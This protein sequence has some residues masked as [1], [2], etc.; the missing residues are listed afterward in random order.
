MSSI[1]GTESGLGQLLKQ[2]LTPDS[3]TTTFP[4]DFKVASPESLLV[5]LG[6]VIQEPNEDY[7][8]E[9]SGSQI[10]FSTAPTT[11]FSL[12]LLYFGREVTIPRVAGQELIR[13]RFSGDGVTTNFPLSVSYPLFEEGVIVFVDGVQQEYSNDWTL[14]N[15]T[16]E[17]VF[18]LAPTGGQTIDV[19]IHGVQRNDIFVVDDNSITRHKLALDW[20]QN[21]NGDW[22]PKI[23]N[24]KDLGTALLRPRTAYIID[25]DFSGDVT[26]QGNLEVLGTQTIFNTTV[27]D[28]EDN[29]ITINSNFTSGTPTIDGG[30]RFLRGD[31]DDALIQWDESADQWLIGTEGNL[32]P[33]ATDSNLLAHTSDTG[34]PH[35][36]T[37]AQVGLGSVTNDAQ[38]K[39]AANDFSSFTI[40]SNPVDNDILLIEDSEDAGNKKYINV[41]A[42]GVGVQD[43]NTYIQWRNSDNNADIGIIKL[44]D[45]DDATISRGTG[46]SIRFK[47][48]EVTQWRFDS[49]RNIFFDGGDAAIQ[50]G[51]SDGADNRR[52]ILAGG[53]S[54]NASRG[55]YVGVYGN[56]HSQAGRVVILSGDAGGGISFQPAGT[57]R[58]KIFDSGNFEPVTD[59]SLYLGST[60]KRLSR[61]YSQRF[62]MAGGDVTFGTESAS[63]GIR[64]V[65]GGAAA[66]VWEITNSDH[67]IP[68]GISGSKDIGSSSNRVGTVYAENLDLTTPISGTPTGAILDFAGSSAP[69]GYLLC[70]G[71]EYNIATYSALH[72]VIGNT[73]NTTGDGVTTFNVP[74]LRGRFSLG[75]ADAGTGS[76]LGE[77]GGS[78]DHTHSISSHTHGVGT[79]TMGL[80]GDHTHTI[81]H[82]HGSF[83]SG[84]SGTLSTNSDSHSHT[85]TGTASSSGSA[86]SHQ[87]N[88][89]DAGPFATEKAIRGGADAFVYAS[90]T[91]TDGAHSHSVSGT[92]NS[93]SHS[94]TISSHTHSINPPSYSGSSGSSGD[95]FHT[96][97]GTIGSGTE[98]GDSGFDSG[99]SNPA[100][101]A[102]N[103]IIKT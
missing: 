78:L 63:H 84:G 70:D 96:L 36:V 56:E 2:D 12:Y 72:T 100:Y 15:N 19:Y 66:T 48:N 47:V 21:S 80:S 10:V 58:W 33:I 34:N 6:G 39:R 67:L 18:G 3:S 95:H 43:N 29:E 4:L 7:V 5:I 98:D 77:T 42:L 59:N 60:S 65:R 11:G 17:I 75:K 61:I 101:I 46:K 24:S 71:T 92:T 40:K 49:S 45:N 20:A 68:Q 13:N 76:V 86:H 37:S 30:F 23:T 50:A 26:I 102:L 94:H 64:F 90:Y 8:L 69:F 22:H 82:D 9:S 85:V 14:D 55:G 38:L 88:I 99:T 28:I 81:N 52:I 35:S 73:Y 62:L 57:E 87:Y 74:D 97:S 93:D 89:N 41:S 16:F 91:Q 25:G 51:T 31:S 79:L 53:G 103:K 32:E 1:I 44:D 83:T 27:L 54:I